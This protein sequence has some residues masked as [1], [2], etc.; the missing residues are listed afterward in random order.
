MFISFDQSTTLIVLIYVDDILI[1]G[2]SHMQVASLITKLNS[3]FALRD[4]GRPTYFL[5]IEVSYHDNY[6]HLS[7]TKYIFYLLHRTEM[8]DTKPVKTPGAVG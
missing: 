6:I 7:Q 8:F 2:S 3:E 5:S 1:T 4:L